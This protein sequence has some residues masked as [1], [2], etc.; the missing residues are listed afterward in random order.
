MRP[1]SLDFLA[2]VGRSHRIAT[3]VDVYRNG[4]VAQ[5]DIAIVDATVTR[6]RNADVMGRCTLTVADPTLIPKSDTDLLAPFGNEVRIRRGVL[7]SSGPELVSL[8]FFQI[9]TMSVADP[10]GAVTLTGFDRAQRLKDALFD[11]SHIVA[12]GQAYPDAIAAVLAHGLP[13]VVTRFVTDATLTPLLVFNPHTSGGHWGAAQGM[14]KSIGCELYFD[15]DG[16]CV[17]RYIP[18]PAGDPVASITDGADGVLI[19]AKKTWDR[20]GGFNAVSVESS[21]PGVVPVRGFAADMDPLS[22]TYYLG[23]YGKKPAPPVTSP[24]LGSQAQA[25]AMAAGMLQ[26]KLGAQQTIEGDMVPNPAFEPG[27]VVQ[28]SRPRLGI[29]EVAVIDSI[30]L[31]VTAQ[32]SAVI[33]TR[34]RQVSSGSSSTGGRLLYSTDFSQGLGNE[35]SAVTSGTIMP[36]TNGSIHTYT[37]AQVTTDAA[38]LHIEAK[39][40]SSTVWPSGMITT[41]PFPGFTGIGWSPPFRWVFQVRST[42]AIGMW[43]SVW[44]TPWPPTPTTI[45]AT[46]ADGPWPN[47]GEGPDLEFRHGGRAVVSAHMTGKIPGVYPQDYVR[48]PD[49]SVDNTVPVDCTQWHQWEMWLDPATGFKWY[50]DGVLVFSTDAGPLAPRPWGDGPRYP[51]INLAVGSTNGFVPMPD[52]TTPLSG[53]F[54]DCRLF[55]VWSL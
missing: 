44:G 8:G 2:A 4:Q 3:R 28:V 46:G 11:D 40:Q 16:V 21:N 41:R 31:G 1:V 20:T 13:G 17:L 19:T 12:A 37:P 25:D 27:D 5:A 24:F 18:V 53:N 10:S 50:L 36:I 43:G 42:D 22:S 51:R 54:L 52:G 30:D 9:Q 32:R 55:Q 39:K 14:A 45:D 6:D 35:W 38:G 7:L 15:G 47:G 23:A 29:S 49:V 26:A 34:T 33:K 48:R